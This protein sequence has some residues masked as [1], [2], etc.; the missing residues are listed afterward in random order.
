MVIGVLI[1]AL[2]GD[3]T[4]STTTSESTDSGDGKGSGARERIKNK[5][6][7]FITIIRQISRQRIGIPTR[8]HRFNN[9]MDFKQSKRSR[10][11]SQNLWALIAG[12]VVLIYTYVYDQNEKK[13]NHLN[14][15]HTVKMDIF[16][17]TKATFSSS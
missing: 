13:I 8:D 12:A 2:L 1:E 6:K 10:W 16:Y 4:V 15:H 14:I 3:P 17:N 5:L 11:L 7:A 9:F